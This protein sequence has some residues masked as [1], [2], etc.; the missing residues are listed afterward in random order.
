MLLP[1]YLRGAAT[2]P[3]APDDLRVMLSRAQAGD[4]AARSRVVLGCVRFILLHVRRWST[5][6][7]THPD[8]LL[9]EGMLALNKSIDTFDASKGFSFFTYAA[10][11]I[12]QAIVRR[13]LSDVS[14]IQNRT[15]IRSSRHDLIA[16]NVFLDAK[17]P[18]LR[19]DGERTILDAF[20]ADSDTHA[21]MESREE[22]SSA[23]A[24]IA[25]FSLHLDDRTRD[26]FRRRFV[27]EEPVTLDEIGKDHGVSRE[28]I[29]QIEDKALVKLSN[30][31]GHPR[32][33]K[34]IKNNLAAMSGRRTA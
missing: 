3:M 32:T 29:R 23:A 25:R 33:A 28:Y 20:A 34:E 11:P 31:V 27:A 10:R 7:R 26:V 2:Q 1:P 19:G 6:P 24:T 14:D 17:V 21:E 22:R 8:D 13:V 12:Q 15:A 4:K 9:A 16:R 5:H 18:S 30:Y